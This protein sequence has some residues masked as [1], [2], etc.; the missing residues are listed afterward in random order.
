MEKISRLLVFGTY[1]QP[2]KPFRGLALEPKKILVPL[3][4]TVNVNNSVFRD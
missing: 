3:L 2:T 4:V 1:L